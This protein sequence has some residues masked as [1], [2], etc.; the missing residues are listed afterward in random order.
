[1]CICTTWDSEPSNRLYCNEFKV[2]FLDVSHLLSSGGSTRGCGSA[3]G[4][5]DNDGYEDLFI[6][7][8]GGKNLLYHNEGNGSFRRITESPLVSEGGASAGLCV[9]GLR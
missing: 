5:Y 6:A 7:N 4:D 2:N 1:M 9:D 3:W 8:N